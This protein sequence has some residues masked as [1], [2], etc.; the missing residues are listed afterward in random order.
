MRR[1]MLTALACL[2]LTACATATVYQ[3]AARPTD[4]GFSEMKIESGRYRVTFQ[5]GD[6]APPTTIA[7]LALLRAAELTLRDGYDWFR[8]TDRE[9]SEAPPHSSS[10]LSIGGGTES[11]GRGGGVGLGMGTTIPLGGGPRA[12]HTLEFLAYHGAAPHSPDAYDARGVVDSV[13]PHAPRPQAAP[14]K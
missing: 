4:V 11:F 6:G 14:A 1:L 13:G 8:I 9:S 7:D 10:S 5:G 2:S 12:I 3:P